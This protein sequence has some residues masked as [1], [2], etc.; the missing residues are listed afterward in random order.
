MEAF[1]KTPFTEPYYFALLT[2]IIFFITFVRYLVVSGAYHYL[3]FV[4]FRSVFQKRI[5]HPSP[6]K[7]GQARQEIY[8]S[9]LTSAIFAV[10][11]TVLVILWQRGYTQLYT[12]WAA[13]PLWYHPLS[14]LLAMFIHETYYY[15]L[16]RWMHRPKVYRKI[17]KWHHD[18]IE[19]SALTSF[20]FHPAESVLQAVVVPLLV[21][22]L[23]MH[24]YLLFFLLFL[25][26]VSGTINHA[27]VEVFPKGAERHWLWKWVVGATHHDLHHR[28]FRFNFG[29]YFTIWDRW[30][31]TE[32]PDFGRRF[33]EKTQG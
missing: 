11:G 14:L 15:W 1:L 18:S 20:S 7:K 28:Q 12:D 10:S 26:T 13:F 6:I 9:A 22:F 4:V 31:G 8:R 27:A 25:M 3:F 17:H 21:L 16:H 30:M 19:T 23:P 24:L 33:R 2:A 29:L 5:L 32:S